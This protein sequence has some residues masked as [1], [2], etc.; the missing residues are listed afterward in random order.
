M[1]KCGDFKATINS[2]IEVDQH[3]L[4]RIEELFVRLQG[5]TEFSKLSNKLEWM[6]RASS[7]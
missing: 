5:G 2:I 4:H 7:F 3:P 6:K 1:V